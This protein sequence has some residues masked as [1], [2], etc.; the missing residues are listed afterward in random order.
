MNYS[1]ACEAVVTRAEAKAEVR[2]HH[3]SNVEG[4]TF[5]AYWAE[6]LLECGD[7]DEYEGSEVLGWLGY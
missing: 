6:F 5:E 3:S 7:R 4:H 1:D 2:R